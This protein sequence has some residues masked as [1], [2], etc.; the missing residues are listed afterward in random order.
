[1]AEVK[2]P[3]QGG[4]PPLKVAIRV[5]APYARPYVWVLVLALLFTLAGS[6]AALLMPQVLRG[7]IDGP[8]AEGNRSALLPA[9]LVVLG[10]GLFEAAMVF[11]RRLMVLGASTRIEYGARLSLFS[12]LVDLPAAFH[13]RWPS[14]SCSPV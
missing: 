12:H 2:E 7:L 10:L 8:I 11:V 6:V 1:M 4:V 13:D 3:T 5:L 9:T 14:G